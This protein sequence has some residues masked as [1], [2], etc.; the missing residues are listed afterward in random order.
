MYCHPTETVIHCGDKENRLHP[1]IAKGRPRPMT[2]PTPDLRQYLTAAYGD[3]E[4]GA[5]C[6]DYFRAVYED[7]ATGM[8]KGQKIQ[9][10]LDYCEHRDLLANLAAALERDRPD[11]FRPRFAATA[12]PRVAPPPVNRDPRRIFISHAHEDADFAHGP[13]DDLTAVKPEPAGGSTRLGSQSASGTRPEPVDGP[14]ST[15]T[16]AS[17]NSASGSCL[18]RGK[19]PRA[20]LASPI[21]LKLICIPAGEFLMGSDPAVGR[22]ADDDEKP[23]H[24]LCLPNFYIG[25]APVTNVQYAAFVKDAKHRVPTHVSTLSAVPC[26]AARCRVWGVWG[27]LRTPQTCGVFQWDG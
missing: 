11:Q 14:Y 2:P 7:F 8:S 18:K 20:V 10:L 21:R 3:E 13:A 24:P 25:Q 15:P 6:A 22:E 16:A 19:G 1:T 9:R 5:L 17:I 12:A 4:L 27:V 23:Q 26:S